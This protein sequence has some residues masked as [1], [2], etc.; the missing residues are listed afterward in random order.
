MLGTVLLGLASRHFRS[1]LPGFLA[2][3]AGDV[4]WAAMVYFGAARIWNAARAGQLALGATAFCFGI[5][6]S[7][8]YQAPWINAIRATRLGG[9]VLG[10]GFLWS[11]MLCYFLGVAL[12][13]A[14]DS[15]VRRG[16]SGQIPGKA[17]LPE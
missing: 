15:V 4:L 2:T 14:L 12:A 10:F 13:A 3:Y 11:D 7:Q 1:V 6:S 9:L 17:K 8:L 16:A 5:E